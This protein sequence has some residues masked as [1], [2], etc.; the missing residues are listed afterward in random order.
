MLS[1]IRQWDDIKRIQ[2]FFSDAENSV[3][4]LPE[5]ARCIAKDKL[6]QAREL[7]GELDA[8]KALLEWKGPRERL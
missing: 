3:S 4:N 5:A 6:A 8:L 2:A 7:V 1:A